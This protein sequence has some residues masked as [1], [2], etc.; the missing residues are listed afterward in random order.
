MTPRFQADEDFN[1]RIVLGLRRREAAVDFCDAREGRVIGASDATVLRLAAESGRILISHDRKTMPAHL[2]RFLENHSSPGVIIVSQELDMGA[3]I[4]DLLIIWAASA[5]E[6]WRNQL[7]FVPLQ[8]QSRLLHMEWVRRETTIKPVGP[9]NITAVVIIVGGHFGPIPI[10]G[11]RSQ[12][13]AQ[14][15]RLSLRDSSFTKIDRLGRMD[16][17]HDNA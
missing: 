3:A 4:E 14:I 1:Q 7:G 17:G 12:P 8:A 5:A 15:G 9:Y 16:P 10:L 11:E 13:A 2:A 6:E